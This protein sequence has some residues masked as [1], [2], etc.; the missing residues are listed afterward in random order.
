M[1][2]TLHISLPPDLVAQVDELAQVDGI[3]R[4]ET[5]LRAVRAYVAERRFD[6]IRARVIP[7]ARKAGFVTDEDVF[8]SVS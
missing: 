8:R 4:E 6:E 1:A 5:I 2:V 3:S 7:Q